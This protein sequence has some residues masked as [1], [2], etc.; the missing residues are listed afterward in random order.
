MPKQKLGE[1]GTEPLSVKI[2]PAT[3]TKLR[4]YAMEA[5]A[6]LGHV[7]DEAIKD[8]IDAWKASRLMR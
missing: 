8:S 4:K 5:K 1:K 2:T 3:M 6:T 7:V